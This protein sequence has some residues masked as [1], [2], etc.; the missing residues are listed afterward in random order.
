QHARLEEL[1]AADPE[2]RR[3]YLE[4]VDLHARLLVHPRLDAGPTL[5]P[6]PQAPPPVP[7]RDWPQLPQVLGYVLVATTTLAISLLAQV[8]WWHPQTPRG[9]RHAAP[10]PTA[11]EAAFPGYV[12]TLAQVADCVWE[13]PREPGQVGSRLRPGGLRL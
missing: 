4:Y 1:L 12:A 3:E 5:P 6:P 10:A 7:A 2:C 8:L 11:V 13:D 9:D